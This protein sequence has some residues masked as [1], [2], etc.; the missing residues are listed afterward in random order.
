MAGAAMHEFA[1]AYE[2]LPPSA[3]LDFI[4]GLAPWIFERP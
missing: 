2:G 1:L 3:D 4:A